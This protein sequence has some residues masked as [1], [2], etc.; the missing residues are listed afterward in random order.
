MRRRKFIAGLGA[1]IGW[2]AAA[3]AQQSDRMR[4][5]GVLMRF[6]EDDPVGLSWVR[7][8]RET[9]EVSGWRDGRNIRIDYRWGPSTFERLRTQAADLLSLKPEV[10]FTGGAIPLSALQQETRTV[11][12]VFAAVTEP[13]AGGFVDSM[14]RPG[15]NITGF[16][17][18][19][20]SMA[21]KWLEIL[22]EVAPRI[23]NVGLIQDPLN[24]DWPGYNSAIKAVSSS[25]GVN[26]IATPTGNIGEIERALFALGQLPQAGLIMLPDAFLVSQRELVISLAAR[27]RLP[28]VYPFRDF[29]AAGGL[30]SYGPIFIELCRGA[31]SYVDRVLRGARPG[32]LPVQ[33]PSKFELVVNLKAANAIGLAV[34]ESFLVRADEVIE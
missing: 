11:P 13:V 27:H 3:R 20:Y 8:F 1:A 14:S 29:A 23:L 12:L 21:G 22:K 24:A 18:F 16:T 28:A 26:V 4:R 32:E 7:A 17:N 34:P 9:L 10:I 19:Q 5:V 2:A 15:G 25:V 6:P 30:V 31:A 33:A